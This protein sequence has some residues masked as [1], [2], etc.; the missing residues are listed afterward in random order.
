VALDLVALDEGAPEVG[1]SSEQQGLPTWSGLRGGDY[2]LRASQFKQGFTRFLVRGLTGVDGGGEQGYPAGDEGG[3]LIPITADAASYSLEVY[4]LSQGEAGTPQA[5]AA[6]TPLSE[7]TATPGGPTEIPSVIQIETPVPGSAPTATPQS[8]ATATP[9]PDPITR[10]TVQPTERPIVTS[11]AV[12]RAQRG[13]VEVRVWGCS[14]SIDTFELADCAQA[15]DGYELRLISDSGEVIGQ[16]DATIGND[17]TVS[18]K[19]LPLGSYLFQQPVML[20]GAVTYYVPNRPLGNDN[21][22]YVVT[23]DRDEPVATIDV[24][25][26][27]A[28]SS[29]AAPTVAPA[30]TSDTDSDGIVDSDETDVFGTDPLTADSDADGVLDGAE[31]AA[32]TDPLVPDS[33]APEEPVGDGDSD[34]DRLSDADEAAFGTDP[35]FADSDGDGFF[36]GDEVNLGTDPLDGSS[37]P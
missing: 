26:L 35:N 21:S 8:R 12:A 29:S 5:A 27:P 32:G 16:G 13:T 14:E 30:A 17:G 3:Y 22:G 4:V 28:P 18:W 37:F 25:N 24:Y 2:A 34:G 33:V 9:R 6:T 10:A 11:T 19:N 1:P 15:V 36:D 23:I 20:A 31:I 7:P